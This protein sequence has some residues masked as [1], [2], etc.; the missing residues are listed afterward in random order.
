[1]DPSSL[2]NPDLMYHKL[3]YGDV[4]W[5]TS[6]CASLLGIALNA[7]LI[8]AIQKTGRRLVYS[9]LFLVAAIFDLF[10]S[11]VEML[12]Q[13]QIAVKNG[14]MFLLPRGIEWWFKDGAFGINYVIFI[15]HCFAYMQ[16]IFILAALFRYRFILAKE[17]HAPPSKYLDGLIVSTIG[18]IVCSLSAAIGVYQASKKGWSYYENVLKRSNVSTKFF[19]YVVDIRDFGTIGYFFGG[20]L[21]S[22]I[23][24][25]VVILYARQAFIQPKDEDAKTRVHQAQMTQALVFRTL[26]TLVFGVWPILKETSIRQLCCQKQCVV[27]RFDA[28]IFG[29]GMMFTWP[30]TAVLNAVI[31]LFIIPPY[32]RYVLNSIGANIEN[33]DANV[34]SPPLLNQLSNM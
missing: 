18:A 15:L 7:L 9:R 34:A 16:G 22:T 10:F 20:L 8:V 31:T 28:E 13:H 30:W 29:T 11:V 24:F 25:A 6:L 17:P 5:A 2:I 12:T 19:M 14:V 27:F 23:S 1:M 33:A 4:L 21:L 32:R 3:T 26:T